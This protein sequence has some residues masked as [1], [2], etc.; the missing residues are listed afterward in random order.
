[1]VFHSLTHQSLCAWRSPRHHVWSRRSRICLQNSQRTHSFDQCTVLGLVSRRDG[2]S[3]LLLQLFHDL[4]TA[5]L[6]IAGC[7]LVE[8]ASRILV[9][10]L[11]AK[12][13]LNFCVCKLGYG[14]RI[15]LPISLIYWCTSSTCCSVCRRIWPGWRKKDAWGDF[16]SWTIVWLQT[17][18]IAGS[19]PT[20][21]I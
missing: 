5:Q 21:L 12:L 9:N 16:D 3:L 11:V 19:K 6:L 2:P 1:M 17:A 10:Y 20:V 18:A 14:A 4:E 13:V 8:L 7:V 15:L